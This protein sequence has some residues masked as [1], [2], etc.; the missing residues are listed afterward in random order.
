MRS[1]KARDNLESCYSSRLQGEF[2][3]FK[4]AWEHAQIKLPT[5]RDLKKKGAQ[6]SKLM[7]QSMTNVC[8]VSS[9]ELF[10]CS[11]MNRRTILRPC[12]GWREGGLSGLSTHPR[13]HNAKGKL[14]PPD[15]LHAEPPWSPPKFERAEDVTALVAKVNK[16]NR[17]L[18]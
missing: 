16:C 6:M 17:K 9:R 12:F 4:N 5:K 2:S 13:V 18:N 11:T 1:V 10:S 7:S 3:C 15:R 8:A 14:R